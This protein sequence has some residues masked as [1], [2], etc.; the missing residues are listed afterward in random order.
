[1][2]LQRS[3]LACEL[4]VPRK[5]VEHHLYLPKKPD[6]ADKVDVWLGLQR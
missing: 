5:A 4:M 2:S 1:M 6:R 3:Y